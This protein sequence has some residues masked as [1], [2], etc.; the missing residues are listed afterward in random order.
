MSVLS[1]LS[2]QKKILLPVSLQLLLLVLV[3]AIFINN[4]STTEQIRSKVAET[5]VLASDL[6]QMSSDAERFSFSRQGY[7]DLANKIRQLEQQVSQYP[8]LAKLQEH[9]Q[10]LQA[11]LSQLQQVFNSN[12]ELAARFLQL[13][14]QSIEASNQYVYDVMDSL[15]DPFKL[16]STLREELAAMS[17]AVKSTNKT[18]QLRLLFEELTQHPEKGSELLG[19][20]DE[21]LEQAKTDVE[22]FAD[23]EQEERVNEQLAVLTQLRQITNDYLQTT[24]L[25]EQAE[26]GVDANLTEIFEHLGQA[27][28]QTLNDTFGSIT[29]ALVKIIVTLAIAIGLTIAVSLLMGRAIVNPIRELKGHIDTLASAGG[30]LTFRIKQSGNDEIAELSQGINHFLATLQGIFQQVKASSSAISESASRNSQLSKQSAELMQQQQKETGDVATSVSQMESAIQEVANNASSA[31]ESVRHADNRAKAVV[32]TINSAISG[33][34]QVSSE[35]DS[36]SHVIQQ[37]NQ[38]SQNISGIL[39]VIRAIADQTN[40]LALNA[41]IE[42]ARAGEQGRGFA[43]VAD[44]VRSLAQR[45]QSSIEEIH[46]M[47]SKLQTASER[48]TE[49]INSSSQQIATT[50]SR[51]QAAGD[52]VRD[53]SGLVSSI[54][55]MNI[56][57]A[58]AVEEQSAVVREINGLIQHIRELAEDSNQAAVEARQSSSLQ[59]DAAHQLDGVTQR[60]RA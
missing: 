40:L 24:P 33:I 1:S 19:L 47:I 42:A 38:D 6:Y 32:D 57:I 2:V 4:Q 52:G 3:V 49:V 60:F 46:S 13:S 17:G 56:Q 23:T 51:S 39:D 55:Q 28:Q 36:A 16:Q 12:R 58:S 21:L 18:Y 11:A 31:A 15:N 9:L 37:L 26:A 14:R 27:E 41:A 8:A 25:L 48:A 34:T 35:L 59:T 5:Q 20:I 10:G 44:E 53:I 22:N 43:V 54:A 29:A 30:D 7:D 45:T 50:V